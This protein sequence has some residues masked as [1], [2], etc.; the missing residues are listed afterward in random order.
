M[1]VLPKESGGTWT[2]AVK[3]NILLAALLPALSN[4]Q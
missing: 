3:I 2:A 1:T 4:T